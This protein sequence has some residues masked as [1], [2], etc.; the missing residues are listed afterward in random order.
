MNS[1]HHGALGAGKI[2]KAGHVFGELFVL[3]RVSRITRIARRYDLSFTME[4]IS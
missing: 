1:Q 3:S 2:L 4:S